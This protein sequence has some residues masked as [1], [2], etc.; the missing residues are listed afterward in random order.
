MLIDILFIHHLTH[1]IVN[2]TTSIQIY[3]N[4]DFG[5]K[6]VYYFMLEITF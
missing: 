2:G 5:I 4:Y 3:K 6:K 1:A